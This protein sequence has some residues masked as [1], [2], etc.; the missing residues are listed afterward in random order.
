[1]NYKRMHEHEIQEKHA[2]KNLDFRAKACRTPTKNCKQTP[3][4][5]RYDSRRVARNKT[6]DPT[7]HL[8]ILGVT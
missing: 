5:E 4:A 8:K 6:T 1:M 3:W 7:Q 2:G